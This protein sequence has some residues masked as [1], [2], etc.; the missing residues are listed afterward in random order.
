MNQKEANSFVKAISAEFQA[1]TIRKRALAPKP[2]KH[3]GFDA[4]AAINQPQLVASDALTHQDK[5]CKQA[6][7]D[8]MQYIIKV[9]CN[10]IYIKLKRENISKSQLQNSKLNFRQLKTTTKFS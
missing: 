5:R 4:A 2:L 9:N 8:I 7:D 10:L 3:S 6:F 1:K